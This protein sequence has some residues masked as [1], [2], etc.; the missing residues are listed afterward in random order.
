MFLTQILATIVGVAI[1][2]LFVK[3]PVLALWTKYK[4]AKD[5]AP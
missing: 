2:D 3:A 4:A 5:A 1:Y